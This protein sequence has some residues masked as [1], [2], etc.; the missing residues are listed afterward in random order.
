MPMSPKG[1]LSLRYRYGKKKLD[2]MTLGG[3]ISELEKLGIRED[4]IFVLREV[5]KYRINMAHDFLVDHL[6]SS[7]LVIASDGSHSSRCATLYFASNRPSMYSI[8]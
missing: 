1:V 2:K 8:F 5:N 4:F 6:R 7:L 3:A